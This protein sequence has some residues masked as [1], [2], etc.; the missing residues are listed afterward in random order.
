[1]KIGELVCMKPCNVSIPLFEDSRCLGAEH[2]RLKPD[3]VGVIL[4]FSE[5]QTPKVMQIFSRGMIGWCPSVYVEV[6]A[7]GVEI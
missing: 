2:H 7:E 4:N 6:Y 3:D 1:M 5:N